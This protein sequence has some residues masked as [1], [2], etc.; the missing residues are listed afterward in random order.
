M[1]CLYCQ[2]VLYDDRDI[3]NAYLFGG[4]ACE[5]LATCDE[6]QVYY[7]LLRDQLLYITWYDIPVKEEWF[8]VRLFLL[9]KHTEVRVQP[10]LD[11][12]SLIF[13][14]PFLV[15]WTPSNA[16]IKIQNY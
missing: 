8:V 2:Q 11:T 1:N 15:N 13:S 9:D 7:H 6:C 14:V 12:H 16:S 10:S 5:R 3:G 4:P